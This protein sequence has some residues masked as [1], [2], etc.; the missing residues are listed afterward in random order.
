MLESLGCTVEVV[1]TG[2]EVVEASQRAGYDVILMDCQM[3]EM[4]GFS[5]T[6][7]IR[8]R[9]KPRSRERVPIIA[10]TAH[11]SLGDRE[12]CLAAGM[13]DYFTKPFTQEKLREVL[14]R[15]L[16]E[17]PATDRTAPP[18]PHAAVHSSKA[19]V[20]AAPVSADAA[21]PEAVA[22]AINRKAWDAITMLQRPGQPDAL[23][24]ILSLYLSDSHQLVDKLRKAVQDREAKLVNEAAH[25]L[26][27]RSAALGAVSLADLCKQ[28]ERLGRT[29]DL[30]EAP[31]LIKQL[32]SE[33]AEACAVF[34]DELQKRAA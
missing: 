24:K 15:W 23:A 8:E 16:K 31:G 21:V 2:R 22:T 14:G 27:S 25:S 26:K 19:P 9:E 20:P 10:L 7:L 18:S 34:S 17:R 5:A 32:E 4:D 29:G 33:F 11:A 6:R 12:Q 30:T 28:L 13:D 1:R 3:P